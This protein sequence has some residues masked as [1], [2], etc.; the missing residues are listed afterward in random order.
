MSV[1]EVEERTFAFWKKEKIYEKAKS[2]RSNA[3][4]F[5]F[6]DGPPYATGA[7]H[8]GTAL[9]KVLK[10]FFIRFLR[11]SG[12]D[13]WD[14]PGYDTHGVPIENKVEK[15]FGFK[16]KKDIEKFGVEKFIKECKKFATEFVDLNSKQFENL[17]VWMD[18]KN[19]YLTLTNEYIEGAWFTFKKG[20]EK[21]LLYKSIYP[22][23]VCPHCETAVAYN[24]I[25]YD[26]AEDPSIYVKFKVSGKKNEYLLIWTTTPWTLPANTGVMVN[27]EAD[28]VRV[29]VGEEI[30]YVAH[31]LLESLMK[32]FGVEKYEVLARI[33][34]KELEGLQYEHPLKDLFKFQ[35]SLENAHR[36]VLSEQFVSLEEGTG[37]VHTAPGHGQEDYKV[38]LAK[39]LPVINPLKMDGKFN[40]ESGILSGIF[41][42]DADRIIIEELEKRGLLA[43][44]EKI[45]HDYPFCWRC[46]S[47]LLLMAVPQWFFKIT[48]IREKL[49]A[50]N[51][52]VKWIPEWAG[53]RF[54]NW[55]ESLGD[56]PVS[57]QRYWGI[58]L[59]I[60][61]CE[62]CQTVKVIGS[63][64]ELP[65]AVKDLHRPF[66][67]SVLLK[68]KKCGGEM[69]RV[70]D[71]L[72]VWFDSGVASWATL[73][74]PKNKELFK[75]WW[76][77][78]FILE[79]PDQIRGWWNSQMITSVLTFGKTPFKSVL[80]HGFVL[81]AHGNKMAKS[82][83]NIVAPEE[84][85]AK[86]GRDVLRYFYL[87]NPPWEDYYFDWKA[88][89]EI[90]KK[91]VILRNAFE[92]VKTYVEN[93]G[94]PENLQ[95]EDRW[96]L[97]KLNS[98]IESVTAHIEKKHPH[99]AA[100]ELIDFI[101]QDF[102][103]WY[104]KLV[105]DRV[106]I[107]YKGKDKKAALYTLYSVT[108]TLLRLLAPFTPFLTEQVYQDFVKKLNKKSTESIHLTDWPKAD[109]KRINKKL[110]EQMEIVK[111]FF[112]FTN[113]A[114]QLAGIKLR[115]PVQEVVVVTQSKK[116]VSALRKLKK[117]FLTATNSKNL[118]FVSKR[119][120]GEFAEVSFKEGSVFLSKIVN[121]KL[122][123]EA[124]LRELIREIQSL[125]K[126]NK[127]DVRETIKLTL[128]TDSETK[129]I[130]EKNR[131]KIL[132]EVGAKSLVIGKLSGKFKGKLEFEEKEIEIAFDR[133]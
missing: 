80:F 124:L 12:F 25:V 114:R 46:D 41:A 71:V 96:I 90:A 4:K 85:I 28:Y 43:F 17:G 102:S 52:K 47:P 66:I 91:F 89:D 29:R 98:L 64:A 130:I 126:Q 81:D 16:T 33:K 20:F 72:D 26:K 13:V 92:F 61:I 30:F 112:E 94:K 77:A 1:K 118:K 105:R 3:P 87:Y 38:G 111:K 24:E 79:G 44:K 110:E 122:M 119:P 125:R 82:L 14:Q 51:K 7:I 27:P 83:G 42:K 120:E 36:V 121:E 76:P 6:L 39:N 57:R 58:P 56:W 18:W 54:K 48:Q 117:V 31:R 123:E 9:N 127:F 107:F 60:W 100:Q 68:C 22:V 67:D 63:R 95:V 8:V 32:K 93:P 128:E 104:I 103:R 74:Y 11:M 55:L 15:K 40:E 113:A 5:F 34:G 109:K 84:V 108:E 116:I 101:L 35:Q 75:K 129:K 45:V 78:D 133:K 10:D 62:K 50:E 106:W 132:K 37:L 19:P 21:G 73:G 97:S 70:P 53:Q 131:E 23:H 99:K 115:W 69:H 86:Y 65:V 88:V 49:L 59:P 2:R